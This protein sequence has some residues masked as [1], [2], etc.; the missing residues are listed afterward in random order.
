MAEIEEAEL[1]QRTHRQHAIPQHIGAFQFKLVG[2]FTLKQFAYFGSLGFLAWLTIASG[3]PI[4][5]KWP[6]AA[7]LAAIGIA[8]AFVPV[9]GRPLD[10]M[11][12][13]FFRA[14]T[15]PTQRVWIKKGSLPEFFH[16]GFGKPRVTTPIT[17][18]AA[19]RAALE[20]YLA[21]FALPPTQAELAET[22]FI[23]KL[24]FGVTLPAKVALAAK[25]VAKVKPKAPEVVLAGITAEERKPAKE[26]VVPLAAAV[27]FVERPVITV[28][29]PGAKP[30]L[31]FPI[32]E[33]KVRKLHSRPQLLG[34]FSLK[35]AGEKKFAVSPELR[36]RLGLLPEPEVEVEGIEE[37][38]SI[39]KL[40]NGKAKTEINEVEIQTKVIPPAPITAPS[41]P[42]V[43]SGI[44][45]DATGH[46]LE[47]V[48][49]IVKNEQ[50]LPV[51]AIKTNL[52]GQFS[53][54]TPLAAGTYKIEAEKEGHKFSIME[55]EATGAVLPP[56]EIVAKD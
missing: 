10:K 41:Q 29:T 13:A 42:N 12:V 51:R 27:N 54:S 16:P 45:K 5:V 37:V 56:F 25:E 15:T 49:L 55:F 38:T 33:V 30:A 1:H 31:L 3:L 36:L 44:V 40:G 34:E 48:I 6:I 14:I 2:Q 39:G 8:F 17:K 32:G 47:G 7:A 28:P 52:L 19:S 46:L 18:T 11:M 21:Q 24:D 23:S 53:I 43:I 4:F 26:A 20:E 35:V 50:G 9:A 22:T